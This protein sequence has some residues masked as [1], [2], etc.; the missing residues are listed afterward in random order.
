MIKYIRAS[1]RL[2]LFF[3]TTLLTVLLVAA[4]NTLLTLFKPRWSVIWKN[5]VIKSWAWVTGFILG[6]RIERKGKPPNPPFFLVSNHLSYI[7]V[8]LLWRYLDATFVAK[9][10]IKSWPFFGWGTRTLGVL[11]INREL[12]RDV[13]RMN[14][15]ISDAISEE[16]GVIIFPEG[17]SSR[18]ENVLPFNAPLLEYPSEQQMPVN[19]ASLS[20]K[21]TDTNNR[22]HLNVCWWGDMPFFSHFWNLL[23]LKKIE[24]AIT[25]GDRSIVE[26]D[27]KQLAQKLQTAVKTNFSPVIAGDTANKE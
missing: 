24:A 14:K 23:K 21:T 17:T 7:D 25:F 16:Q 19:Y 18:G 2:C 5:Y 4:G 9:S 13:P 27:R 11:F 26:A 20:Y 22:P 15:C 3:F 8:V 12:K 10:E 6:L 1:I